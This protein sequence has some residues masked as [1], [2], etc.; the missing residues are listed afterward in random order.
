MN[1]KILD[2]GTEYLDEEENVWVI[3]VIKISSYPLTGMKL[4][5]DCTATVL[6]CWQMF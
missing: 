6:L 1:F 2:S 3:Y 4:V 5:Y